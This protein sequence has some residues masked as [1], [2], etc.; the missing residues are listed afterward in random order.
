[1]A[2]RIILISSFPLLVAIVIIAI[3]LASIGHGQPAASKVELPASIPA[4]IEQV[5]SQII[6]LVETGKLDDANTAVDKIMALPA[7]RDKGYA[8]QLIA[9]AYQDAGQADKAIT[10]SSYVLA[11][12]PKESFAVWAGMS[13]AISQ[14][15]KGNT[16]DAEA[17]T[18]RMIADYAD[19]ND[20]PVALCV[21]ADTYSWRKKF[22]KS[23]KLY[24]VIAE[25]FPGSAV[26]AKARLAIVGVNALAFIEDKDYSRAKGQVD[27]MIADFNNKPDL[28]PMLFR[29]GQEF[30]WR[31]RYSEAKDIFDYTANKSSDSSLSQQAKLWFARSNVCS[32]IGPSTSSGQVKDT[33]I[34]A[35]IDKLMSDFAGD[36]G[37]AEAVYWI[38]KEY[39]WKKGTTINRIGWYD[40]P[41]SV[42]Q[43]I[44]QEFGDT[45]YGQEAQWDQKRL[46]H[47]MKIF[48]LM[49]EPNQAA[50]DAAIETMAAD[51]KG[52]PELASELYWVAC[53]YE[54]HPDK[55]QQ[56]KQIYE[57]VVKDRPG[58]DEADR[59]ALDVRRRVLSDV[60]DSGDVNSAY[61]LVDKFIADFKQNSYAGDC[62]GRVV[63]GCYKRAAE[64]TAQ[65]QP[66]KAMRY[67][68]VSANIWERIQKENLQ[69]RSDLAYLY[70]YVAINYHEMGR[71]ADAI[72]NYQ[73][74]LEDW[75]DFEY[76]CSIN[77]AIAYCYESLRDKEGVPKEEINP[78]IEQA[79]IAVVAN[80][81][82]CY[83]TNEVA[84]RLAGMMLEKGD[85]VSAV[86]YYRKFLDSAKP[87]QY[88]SAKCGSSQKQDG[89]IEAVKSKL[90]E[91][92]AE[93]GTN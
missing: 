58:T 75:P 47:R 41:N 60:L 4:D 74:V 29:I 65:G 88:G 90:A 35:A 51:L 92:I 11:N 56:A 67:H 53:G 40:T 85:K 46:A 80:S 84:Y 26:A 89:K 32:L 69:I 55:L 3:V 49:Q 12:W 70:F 78:L 19:N 68:E 34:V 91:L 83:A 54:E 38:S 25:K 8:L 66:E 22:D 93:G 45:P 18:S 16:A 23:E 37:L 73:K 20:L 64:L 33:E 59:A 57:R 13:M 36:A 2:K 44:M 21:V 1:M 76:A 39:E 5:K 30:S 72:N 28:P 9:G 82:G 15:D 63:I 24:A 79:F 10:I 42:Y 71:W 52:R 77:A 17:T 43:K 87:P 6:S 81:S 61:T 86:K 62:L 48:K 50:T 14:V 31:H 27:L 7:S